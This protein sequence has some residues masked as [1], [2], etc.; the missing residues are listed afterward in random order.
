MHTHISFL[1]FLITGLYV[2][3]FAFTWRTAAAMW[4]ETNV[5]KAMSF[6]L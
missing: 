6:I 4:A 5:G 3:L 1:S 2:I